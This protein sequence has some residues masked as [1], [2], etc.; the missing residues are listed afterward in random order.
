[1]KALMML[2]VA[3][4]LYAAGNN[5][6]GTFGKSTTTNKQQSKCRAVTNVYKPAN[7]TLQFND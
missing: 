1:M 4:G 2:V 3:G 6:V 5:T 7:Y